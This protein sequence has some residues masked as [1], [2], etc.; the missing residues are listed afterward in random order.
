VGV[1]EKQEEK[2]GKRKDVTVWEQKA[3]DVAW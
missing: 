1:G 2:K 3:A